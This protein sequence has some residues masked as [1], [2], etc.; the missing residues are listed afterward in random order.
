MRQEQAADGMDLMQTSENWTYAGMNTLLKMYSKEEIH[1]DLE[2]LKHK[3]IQQVIHLTCGIWD[4]S[5]CQAVSGE[6]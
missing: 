6:N 4:I 1:W 3:D 2:G 5:R